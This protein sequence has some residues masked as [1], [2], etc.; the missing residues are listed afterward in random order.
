MLILPLALHLFDNNTNLYL[1]TEA[2]IIHT[3]F[4]KV[5][6]LSH[7]SYPIKILLILLSNILSV[8]LLHI[9]FTLPLFCGN[10]S[11]PICLDYHHGIT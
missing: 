5:K 2:K 9:Q 3:Q 11:V 4:L 6:I 1:V 8:C 7:H 10:L